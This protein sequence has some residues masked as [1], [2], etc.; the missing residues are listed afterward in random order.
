MLELPVKNFKNY[1]LRPLK[2]SDVSDYFEIGKDKETVEFL[3]WYPFIHF[4]EAI[5]HFN[6][7]YFSNDYKNDPRA[8]AIVDLENNK[9]IG[10][11]D[12]HLTN[13][14]RKTAHIGYLLN[15]QYWNL[16]IMS[17]AVKI[18]VEVGFEFLKLRKIYVETI[19]ENYSSRRVCEKNGF[20]LK[21]IDKQAHYQ[22]KTNTYYD[23][24]KYVIERKS[25]N[26]SKTKGNV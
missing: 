17:E 21:K 24:Y 16:G 20:K 13:R 23:I 25:Y 1:Q 26:D 11:I 7:I 14:W 2:E 3:S 15:K 12:F 8:Y 19:K 10:V 6:N 18:M 22:N 5:H 4:R 9:M